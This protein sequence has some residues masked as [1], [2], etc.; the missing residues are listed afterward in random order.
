MENKK[1]CSNN[2]PCPCKS[3]TCDKHGRCCECVAN[4]KKQGNL[5]VCLR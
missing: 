3:T 2:N 4:H 1:E 5:P